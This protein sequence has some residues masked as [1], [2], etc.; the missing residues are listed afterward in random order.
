MMNVASNF[1]E[2]Q[3]SDPD[4]SISQ[5]SKCSLLHD[6]F[7]IATNTILLSLKRTSK[8]E[9]MLRFLDTPLSSGIFVGFDVFRM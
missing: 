1:Q 5:R 6:L 2:R 8:M 7:K 4:A 3:K 9:L